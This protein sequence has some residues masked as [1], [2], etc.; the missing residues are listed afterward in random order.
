MYTHTHH[1]YI[2]TYWYVCMCICRYTCVYVYICLCLFRQNSIFPFHAKS[3]EELLRERVCCKQ[4]HIVL[5][6][7]IHTKWG[8]HIK[9]EVTVR[10][11]FSKTLGHSKFKAFTFVV[12]GKGKLRQSFTG[13]YKYA[14]CNSI[15]FSSL[16]RKHSKTFA[17]IQ[18]EWK[19][20]QVSFINQI[21]W[22]PNSQVY[23]CSRKL[24]KTKG[25][26]EN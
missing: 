23:I 5:P 14:T 7:P 19:K 18:R 2:H 12:S 16:I 1:I 26:T 17:A 8:F 9:H 10:H 3:N 20:S 21:V 15:L 22:W 24:K 6:N 4:V 13:F 11:S 25:L